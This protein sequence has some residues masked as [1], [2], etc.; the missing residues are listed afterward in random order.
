[1]P[2]DSGVAVQLVQS[3]SSEQIARSAFSFV[4]TAQ[5]ASLS[6][7][8]SKHA[9][10]CTLQVSMHMPI[11]QTQLFPKHD[12][13][14]WFTPHP[15]SGGVAGEQV[16]VP[17]TPFMSQPPIIPQYPPLSSAGY[18]RHVLIPSDCN[19]EVQAVQFFWAAATAQI[20]R[21]VRVWLSM[22]QVDRLSFPGAKHSTSWIVSHES[23]HCPVVQTQ[24]EL[25][26]KQSTQ[27]VMLQEEEEEEEEL[28]LLLLLLLP[29]VVVVVVGQVDCPHPIK[30]HPPVP[31]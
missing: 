20:A 3:A 1:M 5:M 27:F 12:S 23:R 13:Q 31:Q 18:H 25:L 24:E 21:S 6:F 9:T 26:F 10:S 11:V 8:G 7:P 2:S 29:V 14:D 15:L 4:S 17:Q 19:V 22:A 28:L 30:L 16:V